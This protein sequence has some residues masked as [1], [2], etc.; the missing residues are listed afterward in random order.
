M[1]PSPSCSNTMA[2]RRATPVRIHS[3]SSRAPP[4][5]ANGISSGSG[6]SNAPRGQG[7]QVE[8]LD[9]ASCGLRQLGQ[10]LDPAR[11]LVSSQ[12]R[13]DMLLDLLGEDRGRLEAGP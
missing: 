9:L 8:A 6:R 7:S 11:R 3:Y 5:S 12:A 2:G 13:L 4:T 1:L 10:E